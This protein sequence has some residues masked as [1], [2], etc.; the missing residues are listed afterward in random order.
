M[1]FEYIEDSIID[2][3]KT[4]MPYLRTVETYAGQLEDEIERLPV[5][6]PAAYVVYG[7]SSFNWIDGP[8]HQETVEFS[9]LVAAKNLRGNRAVRKGGS[10]P[11]DRGAYDL[12]N[13]VL[14]AL[15]N[16]TFGLEI[17]RLK[18]LRVSLVFISRVIA[19]YGID[20]Q[21]S[22]DRTHEW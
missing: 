1:N 2:A 14:A 13:D 6:F 5:R 12:I 21:T 19:V 8:N 16:K 3:L 9:V 11:D 17:E 22:F 20:F 7:G 4:A 15:T 18:P 10:A